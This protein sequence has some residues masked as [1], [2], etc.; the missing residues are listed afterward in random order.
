[1]CMFDSMMR[2][3]HACTCS[4]K[5]SKRTRQSMVLRL[6]SAVNNPVYSYRNDWANS[7]CSQLSNESSLFVY[8][9]IYLFFN[10]TTLYVN[11]FLTDMG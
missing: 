8:L 6:N 4:S 5:L 3:D 11:L 2:T 7:V 1:M 10:S 9:F